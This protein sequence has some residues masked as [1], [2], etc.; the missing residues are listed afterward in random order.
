MKN[1]LFSSMLKTVVLLNIFCGSSDTFISG[2]FD[3]WEVRTAILIYYIY[4][5]MMN[6]LSLLINLMHF[7]WI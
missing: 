2:F 1:F 4:I 5:I 6:L 3:K 7:C